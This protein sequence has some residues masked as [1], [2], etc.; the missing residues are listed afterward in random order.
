ME[1]TTGTRV[2]QP[3]LLMSNGVYDRQA[4]IANLLISERTFD[5]WLDRGLPYFQEDTKSKLFIGEEVMRFFRQH[6][7]TKTKGA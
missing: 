5:K 6:L 7:K 1:D 2:V 3:P 4:I